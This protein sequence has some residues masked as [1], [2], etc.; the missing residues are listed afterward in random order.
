MSAVTM[1]TKAVTYELEVEID[2]TPAVVWTALTESTDA[3]WLPDFHMTGEGSVVSFE[4]RAG[5]Q[6]LETHENGSSL[7]WFT[8]QMCVVGKALYLVGH[9]APEW[10]GPATSMLKLG[11][12]PKGSGTVLCVQDALFGHVSDQ[13]AQSLKEGWTQLLSEGLKPFAESA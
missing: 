6:L 3:W 10:T 12:E 1:E 5:G 13:N 7:L 11:I 4:A 8:V 2:A 9:I